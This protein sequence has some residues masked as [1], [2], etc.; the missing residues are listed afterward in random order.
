MVAIGEESCEI[1]WNG[2]H[3]PAVRVEMRGTKQKKK[4]KNWS[5]PFGSFQAEVLLFYFLARRWEHFRR[6][7]LFYKY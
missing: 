3:V 1:W 7:L 2:T 6:E 5:L 4:K